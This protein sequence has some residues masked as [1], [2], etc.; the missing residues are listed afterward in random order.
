VVVNVPAQTAPWG[1]NS[2]AKS[3]RPDA[4]RPA[5]LPAA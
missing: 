2:K 3:G 5:V 1:A 4:F